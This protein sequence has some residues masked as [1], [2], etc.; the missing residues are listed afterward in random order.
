MSERQLLL[1]IVDALEKQGLNPDE[2]QLYQWVDIEALERLF[3]S[4]D[5]DLE[6]RF[7]VAEFHVL[8]TQ[9]EVQVVSSS[10]AELNQRNRGE[11]S[12]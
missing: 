6:V 10:E 5:A 3:D 7:A 11:E 4:S 9:S 12:C 1:E 8:V 2:F